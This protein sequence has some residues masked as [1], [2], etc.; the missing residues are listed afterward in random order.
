MY[1]FTRTG[2]LR[3]GNVRESMAWALG[4][5]EKVNQITGLGVT[6]WTPSFSPGTGTV[7]W[8]APVED[9]IT[10]EGANDKLMV[11]DGFVAELDRG[12]QFMSTDGVDDH[13]AQ[14][15]VGRIDTSKPAN[16]VAIVQSEL[17]P[18]GFAKGIEAGM[19]IAKRATELGGLE[20]LF[21]IASTGTYGGVSWAT[22]AE[23]LDEL[24]RAEQAV[25]G[26]EGFTQ[27]ID[28][29]APG[30]YLPGVTTQRIIRRLA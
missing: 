4:I 28:S 18:G 6:L 16:Y 14:L 2:R 15:L 9:L 25:N 19:E 29:V 7:I 3:P 20:T 24:Q 12:A 17:V 26:D 23:S 27:Y 1:L 5:T 30:V 8:S 11:D 22:R 13:L 21:L 10:L